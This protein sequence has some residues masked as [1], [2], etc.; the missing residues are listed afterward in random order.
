MQRKSQRIMAS[1]IPL[2]YFIISGGAGGIGSA[3]SRLLPSLGI[4]PIVCFNSNA[5]AAKQLAKETGGF[6]V[7]LDMMSEQSISQGISIIEHTLQ[8]HDL[9]LG[10]IL[11]ASPPPDLLPFSKLTQ[12][13]F[14]DQFQVNVAG[15]H[16]LLSSLLNKFFRKNKTGQIIGILSNAIGSDSKPPATGM[17]AY[18]V[19]KSSMQ[20]LLAVCSAEYP[21][22]DVTSISPGFTKTKMLEVFDERY[23]QLVAEKT[24]ISDPEDIAKTIV[25]KIKI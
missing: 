9:L 5:K 24:P 20:S 8:D 18:V 13:H 3:V 11:G 23:I 15:P 14:L 21:W 25:H 17:G 10:L 7:Q 22:L 16:F 19:A 12:K 4:L 1:M 6:A 2:N